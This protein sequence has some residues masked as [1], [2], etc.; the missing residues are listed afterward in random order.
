M[1]WINLQ[2][3][4]VAVAVASASVVGIV[5]FAVAFACAGSTSAA[6]TSVVD[7]SVAVLESYAAGQD[8]V[9]LG[10]DLDIG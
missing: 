4:V 6:G 10:V 3:C 1:H 8:F 5:A 2:V 9:D 7:T